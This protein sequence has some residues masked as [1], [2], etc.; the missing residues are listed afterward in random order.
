VTRPRERV[1]RR[2]TRSQPAVSADPFARPRLRPVEAFPVRARN[3]GRA[4]ALRDP[5]GYTASILTVPMPLLDIL[6]LLDGDHTL[7]DIQASIMR[8]RGELVD[9]AQIA[10]LVDTLDEHGFL[11]SP[12]FAERQLAIDRAFLAAAARPAVHAGGAYAGTPAA[13]RAML[14]RFFEEPEGPGAIRWGPTAG[15]P[16]RGLVAPHIDFHRGGPAYAWGYRPL[17]EQADADCFV[18]LGTCHAGMAE[19]FALTAKDYDTPLGALRVDRDLLERLV[20]RA[21]GDLFA[22]ELAHRT[23]HSIEFQAVFLRYLFDGRRDVTIVPVLASFVHEA[24]VL[25]RGP[26]DDP[27]VPRFLDALADT[28]A[29]SNRRVCVIAGADLAHIGPQFG[30]PDDVTPAWLRQVEREDREMLA[31]VEAGDP[32]AFFESA[33]RDGDRRRVCGLSPIYALLR[34]LPRPRGEV[35]RYAQWPDPGGTVTFASVTLG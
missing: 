26:E 30:D 6:A 28:V 1:A 8:R 21:G 20:R 34:A 9:T 15:P 27:R 13:L 19:P 31:A 11:D 10:T 24:L 5:R 14:D 33:R 12:A 32:H 29:G 25:G 18:I 4:I 16:L 22:S 35:R 3:G 2:A 17:A 7:R 23:E